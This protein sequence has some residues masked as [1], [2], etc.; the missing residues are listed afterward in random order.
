MIATSGFPTALECTEFVFR[1]DPLG[2]L[3]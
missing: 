3:Y 2:E 1:P